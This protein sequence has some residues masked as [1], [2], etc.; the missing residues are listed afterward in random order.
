MEGRRWSELDFLLIS[1]D[2][3]VDHPSF[4][5]A[6]I[7]RVLSRGGYRVG[8]LP[9]P[10]WRSTKDFLSMGRPRLGVLVTAGNMDSMVSKYTSSKKIRTTDDYAPGGT[11]GCRP[12]RASIVYCSRV[13]EC[14][15]DIPIVIG[16]IEVSLRR[17]AHYDY[18]SNDVRR[19]ILIDSQ[20][21]LLVYGMGERQIEEIAAGLRDGL[22]VSDI[23][24]VR[25]TMYRCTSVP[26]MDWKTVGIPSF[27]EVA[28]DK[29]L[30][31]EAFRMATLE[32][33]PFRGKALLQRHGQFTV[34]QNPPA[35]P[36]DTDA[37]DSIYDLPYTRT[38]HPMYEA[39]G[40]VPAIKEVRFSLTSHRGC[41]G[42][43]SFC[44]IHSHQGRIIQARSHDSLLK[45]AKLLTTLPDFKGYIHDVGGPTA[46]FRTPSCREQF[47]RG[48]CR[49]RQCLFPEPCR[50]LRVDHSDY[51]TL[52]RALRALPGVKKVFIR[53]GI[54]YDYL[55]ADTRTT[56]LEE[57]CRY[58]VSGQL[59][60][61][62]EHVSEGILRLMRKSNRAAYERFLAEYG[63]MNEKLG[64]KQY[65][66]PY[67]I[68]SHPGSTLKD[69]VELAEFLRDARF[70]PDQV[71]DFIPTPGSLSTCM[72]YTGLDPM[73]G[74]TV[75]VPSSPE[76]RRMQRA[77][78][79]YKDPRNRAMVLKALRA[80]GRGDLIGRGKKCLVP[81]DGG[82]GTR[83]GI[84]VGKAGKR[85]RR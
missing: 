76:E 9:Q 44:A 7:S 67:F 69:A 6:V 32:Q 41:F 15:S 39:A 46:N 5:A 40:G 3:Y 20:A 71:Q 24:R 2:A 4:A 50:K 18:W 34:V 55:L 81:D 75:F 53:S 31:A 48:T 23:R 43:C 8:I 16:G 26:D 37:L 10:D 17:F 49:N 82:L 73:T 21:D 14:W 25:G 63:A 80:A 57:L 45:E 83:D 72:Y 74:A 68:A 65:L 38:Y 28:S 22:P 12:D 59:K 1:G 54:R 33:D 52:L 30:F 36:L 70:Q 78:L 47:E 35:Y 62:P 27:E 19:S 84:P 51:V 11:G 56:F 77:L 66:I 60:V 58:H 29:K 13:R 42:S 79:Q 61:A 85:E 64:K